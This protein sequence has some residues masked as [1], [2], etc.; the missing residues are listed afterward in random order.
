[1][2][3]IC[4]ESPSP[5]RTPADCRMAASTIKVGT[6]NAVV[7]HADVRPKGQKVRPPMSLLSWCLAPVVVYGT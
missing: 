4:G 5:E 2:S 6:S 7:I 1:M 3:T